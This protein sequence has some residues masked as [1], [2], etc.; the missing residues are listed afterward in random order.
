MIERIVNFII[1]QWA[2]T[3]WTLLGSLGFKWHIRL[4]RRWVPTYKRY[5]REGYSPDD[6]D[7][8]WSRMMKAVTLTVMGALVLL[9]GIIVLL[10][11][12]G[13]GDPPTWRGFVFIGVFLTLDGGISF[14]G[15]LMDRE[16]LKQLRP[17]DSEMAA[18]LDKLEAA[19]ERG[20]TGV[21]SI[22]AEAVR[23]ADNLERAITRAN[24]IIGAAPPG[25]AAD[26][27]VTTEGENEY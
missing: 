22:Q 10:G 4:L 23:V 16:D 6:I 21:E 1:V 27:A 5:R 20:N 24:D 25:A 17:V 8:A 19:V 15:Y 14:L 26:A 9:L 12:T 11:P 13:Q 3:I 2:A 7:Y 18:R